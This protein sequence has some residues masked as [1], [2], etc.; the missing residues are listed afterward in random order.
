MSYQDIVTLVSLVGAIVAMFFAFRNSRRSDDQQTREEAGRLARI[1]GKLD[2][3]NRG[4]DDVRVE[5]RSHSAQLIDINTR[6]TRCEESAKSA[7]K[8][9]DTLERSESHE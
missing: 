5:V 9:I 4:I 3:A 2:S 1:E 6:M 7:H 8:R